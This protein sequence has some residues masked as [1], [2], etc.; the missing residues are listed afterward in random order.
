MHSSSI[1]V[2]YMLVK[3]NILFCSKK[4]AFGTEPV[5]GAETSMRLMAEALTR[6]DSSSVYLIF[7]IER[8][9]S[10]PEP[11]VLDGITI[12]HYFTSRYFLLERIAGKLGLKRVVYALEK[13]VSKFVLGRLLQ[14]IVD[15]YDIGV[16][17]T[18][19]DR[20]ILL[21][22]LDLKRK[23]I[24]TAKIV[25]RMAGL[26]WYERAVGDAARVDEYEYIFNNVDSINYLSPSFKKLA[27]SKMYELN[28]R[29]SPKNEFICDI[30]SGLA[31]NYK[32]ALKKIDSKEFLMVAVMRFSDYQKRQDLLL[33]ALA[34]IK[35]VIPV[36]A[37][38]I[39]SGICQQEMVGLAH[40]L[41]IA[42]RVRFVEFLT[43]QALWQEMGESDLLCHPCEY[44]GVSKII[45]ESMALGLP[46]LASN[47][48]PL[49]DYVCDGETGFLVDNEP[50]AWAEKIIF[51]YNN[52]DMLDKAS[53]NA[54]RY[55]EE[56]HTPGKNILKYIEH[57][58]SLLGG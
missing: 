15:R 52:R 29:V 36:K 57:F 6:A 25:M 11:R 48:T 5:G 51:L 3:M 49:Q 53:C 9:V 37:I 33:H 27:E 2:P 32:A 17:Y 20:D 47:V 7:G 8:K 12:Y 42:D 34:S 40:E 39:G 45:L 54:L 50:E 23:K 44:E 55:I 38:F 1:V 22:L 41:G 56:H 26:Y 21:P 13:A 10:P 46:V 19:Y 31:P 30:G 43:Q 18:S 24:I 35:D 28:M 16:M 58:K 14:V 4:T